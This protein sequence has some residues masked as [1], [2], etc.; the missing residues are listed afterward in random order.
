M[1][2]GNNSKHRNGMNYYFTAS[3]CMSERIRDRYEKTSPCS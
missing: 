3:G 1:T 2:A